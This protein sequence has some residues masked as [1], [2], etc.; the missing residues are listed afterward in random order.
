MSQPPWNEK[1]LLAIQIEIET[2]NYGKRQEHMWIPVLDAR[3]K[4][5]L[6]AQRQ[7]VLKPPLWQC[8]NIVVGGWQSKELESG[9]NEEGLVFFL[10]DCM[11][12]T[13]QVVVDAYGANGMEARAP[14]PRS[15]F[16][17]QNTCGAWLFPRRMDIKDKV[18]ILVN[19]SALKRQQLL[20]APFPVKKNGP[21]RKVRRDMMNNRIQQDSVHAL[22]GTFVVANN[23]NKVPFRGVRKY[24]HLVQDFV[25]LIGKQSGQ[26]L[27]QEG[28][29]CS[30]YMI[31]VKANV[32]YTLDLY[33]SMNYLKLRLH[34]GGCHQDTSGAR[35]GE[36]E[37][38]DVVQLRE[39]NWKYAE[40]NEG[41]HDMVSEGKTSLEVSRKGSA[42]LRIVFPPQTFWDAEA[43]KEV[44]ESCNV[45]LQGVRRVLA[46]GGH[47]P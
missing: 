17:I 8:A 47:W 35:I 38:C 3:G 24:E 41:K 25:Q 14:N 46:G 29:C 13:T 34:N 15:E 5:K 12:Q 39:I 4:C 1:G 45:L 37:V 10:V 27:L 7:Y 30:I 26:S 44:L 32:G 36:L 22:S 6:K 21:E 9:W 19:S 2:A 18:T 20:M 33:S 28:I 23:T 16:Q 43:E 42:V 40:W 31:I 11:S